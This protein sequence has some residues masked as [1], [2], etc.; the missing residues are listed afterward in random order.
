M[1][2][3]NL[4]LTI[5][6]LSTLPVAARIEEGAHAGGY[7]IN[8][9]GGSLE[10]LFQ[11]IHAQNERTANVVLGEGAKEVE[12]APLQLKGVSMTSLAEILTWT[13]PKIGARHSDN[14]V[15]IY[16]IREDVFVSIYNIQHLVRQED[17]TQ[18]YLLEDIA[19]TI[20]TGWEMY[21]NSQ[22]PQMKIHPGTHLII[23][24]GTQG[25][26]GI[27]R[28]ILEQL[29]RPDQRMMANV[30]MMEGTVRR[31]RSE[32]RSLENALKSLSRISKDLEVRKAALEGS[33]VAEGSSN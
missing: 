12:V 18:A 26:H 28:E 1:A 6:L 5:C 16:R 15:S 4:I 17:D 13:L 23:V 21:D 10:M 22:D 25:E 8:F 24:Q 14:L 20:K 30:K 9:S 27:V 29:I 2:R 19:T 3:K 31:L 11:V 7:D 32:I 33:D